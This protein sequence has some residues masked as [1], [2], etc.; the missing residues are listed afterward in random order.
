MSPEDHPPAPEHPAPDR[1]APGPLGWLELS[2]EIMRDRSHSSWMLLRD[3]ELLGVLRDR[4]VV[5]AYL[6]GAVR[7]HPDLV[8]LRLAVSPEG[9]V[10][11]APE[12][13]PPEPGPPVEGFVPWLLDELKTVSFIPDDG[14]VGPPWL[15]TEEVVQAAHQLGEDSRVVYCYQ[16]DDLL[17]A[18]SF[19][20]AIGAPMSVYREDG[21]VVA[22][23]P[24]GP[25]KVLAAPP[26]RLTGAYPFLLMDRRGQT[27][28]IAY[29]KSA[30]KDALSFN[31]EWG[32]SLWPARREGHPDTQELELWLAD[33]GLWEHQH[34]GEG[35]PPAQ[36]RPAG[37]SAEQHDLIE[38]WMAEREDASG[39]LE[40]VAGAFGVPAVAARLAETP[41]GEP[42]PPGGRTVEPGR[43]GA[44]AVQ[45]IAEV[46]T[47]PEGS[48]PWT[49]LSRAI[50]R[51][52]WLGIALGA[53][54][55]LVALVLAGMA[56]GG[57]LDGWWVWAVAGVFAVAA[58]MYLVQ[59]AFRLRVRGRPGPE[60]GPA[61][62]LPSA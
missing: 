35:T 23:T 51:R 60:E 29:K 14:P 12:G 3:E 44:L 42:D 5:A 53:G 57:I 26:S 62:Q 48:M 10:A 6:P 33:P 28:T 58:A 16:S 40:Q 47:E 50:W 17:T 13:G 32:P 9:K 38:R 43:T 55:L 15:P 7:A 30:K 22:A 20:T 37:M 24:H 27:R 25:D 31:A 52:P 36:E 1:P 39:F 11:L 56:L 54:E 18:S 2:L 4:G 8:L 46:D 34:G 41:P 59:S 49:V 45:S 61:E 19:A 21:W